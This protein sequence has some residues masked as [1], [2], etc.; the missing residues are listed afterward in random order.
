VRFEVPAVLNMKM[1]ALWIGHY[2]V[3]Q[4]NI[5]KRVIKQWCQLLRSYNVSRKHQWN[6]TDNGKLNNLV[7]TFDVALSNTNP[8]RTALVLSPGLYN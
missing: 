8:T 5:F 2:V 4:I 3:W 1:A 7:K 6:E